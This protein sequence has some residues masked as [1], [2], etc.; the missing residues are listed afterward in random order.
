MPIKNQNISLIQTVLILI[1]SMIAL[2]LVLTKVDIFLR[3]KAMNDCAMASRYETKDETT[4][5][6]VSYPASNLYKT[7]LKE[8]G[9]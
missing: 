4:G 1:F 2:Q 8:K 9:Y 3:L 5:A 6:T 7:C